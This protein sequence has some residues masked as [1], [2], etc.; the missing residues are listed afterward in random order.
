MKLINAQRN[1][2][3]GILEL[4]IK[5]EEFPY[6]QKVKG[7]EDNVSFYKNKVRQLD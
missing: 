6:Q 3:I 5:A 7:L 1:N 2:R 4:Q